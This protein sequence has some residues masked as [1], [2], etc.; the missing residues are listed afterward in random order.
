MK[1]KG[2]TLIEMVV[3]IVILGVLA[4]TAAPKFMGLQSDARIA[5]LQATKGAIESSFAMFSAKSEIPSTEIQPCDY[6]KQMRCMVIDGQ[7][8][9]LTNADNYPWFDVFPN[10]ALSQFKALVNVDVSPL[11]DDLHGEDKLNFETDYDG[12][13]WIFPQF[14]GDW[15]ELDTL[16]CRIHYT[17]ATASRTGHSITTLETEDC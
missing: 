15:S 5:T 4:V 14:Y 10:Q 1:N 13:F 6:H 3:V 2:F 9:R 17:P 7:Q 11:N 16:R 8:I 12:G